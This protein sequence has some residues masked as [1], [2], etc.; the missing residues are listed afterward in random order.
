MDSNGRGAGSVAALA[1]WAAA[2]MIIG[3]ANAQESAPLYQS[4]FADAPPARVGQASRS[5]GANVQLVVLAPNRKGASAKPSPR[6]AWFLSAASTN[7]LE[8]VVQER[9]ADVPLLERRIESAGAGGFHSIDLGEFGVRLEQGKE[10]EWSVALINDPARR[11]S[12]Q[13]SK[14]VVQY[15]PSSEALP[16]GAPESVVSEYLARGYWYDAIA[17]MQQ[18]LQSE[19]PRAEMVALS[20]RVLAAEQLVAQR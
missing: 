8:I 7:P 6:L 13:F 3:S 1:T 15:V 10:Y 18:T 4:P 17:L 14:G 19:P 2:W 12:D 11:A 9:G 16:S 20:Q 5:G